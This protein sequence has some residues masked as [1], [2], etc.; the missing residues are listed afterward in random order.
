[1]H[2]IIGLMGR[3]APFIS[4]HQISNQINKAM[5]GTKDLILAS[6]LRTRGVR[7]LVFDQRGRIVAGNVV[8]IRPHHALLPCLVELDPEIFRQ[9]LQRVALVR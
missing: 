6:E 8:S 3:L 4:T 2:V 1:M 9:S 7:A 5:T